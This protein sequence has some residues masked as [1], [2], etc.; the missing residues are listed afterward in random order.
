[1][2][3]FIR[4]AASHMQ[5]RAAI[6]AVAVVCALWTLALVKHDARAATEDGCNPTCVIL[7]QVDGLEPKDVTQQTTPYLWSLAHPQVAGNPLP[8]GALADRSGF[9]WQAPR[10]VMSTGTASATASLLTGAH[11]ERSGVPS[12]DFYDPT[13]GHQRLGAGGFGDQNLADDPGVSPDGAGP[14]GSSGVDTLVDAV[15][16]SGGDVAVF[17]GD[18]ALAR[19]AHADDAAA[20]WYP[21]GQDKTTS[22]SPDQKFTGDPRLC[23]IPRYPADTAPQGDQDHSPNPSACPADDATTMNKAASDLTNLSSTGSVAFTFIHLAELGVAKR[24][25]NISNDPNNSPPQPP[26]AL[27]DTDAAIATLAEQYARSKQDKWAK[28]VLMVVGSHGY[29]TATPAHRVPDPAAVSS[30]PNNATNATRDLSDYVQAFA[31][32]KNGANVVRAGELTLVP[33]GTLATIYY[34]VTQTDE[35]KID[36]ARR[37]DALAAIK[38]DLERPPTDSGSVNAACARVDPQ[39]DSSLRGC[40]REVDY[41]DAKTPGTSDTVD[42]RHPSW[43][44]DALKPDSPTRSNASGGLV[45]VLERGWATGRAA[46]TPRA[47]GLDPQPWSNPY[48]ASSGGPQERAV[49]ALINGPRRQ[50]STSPVAVRNLDTLAAG[51][52]KYYPVS[53]R[54]VDPDNPPPVTDADTKCPDTPPD[55]GGLACANDPAQVG[56]DAGTLGHEAQPVSVDF[57]ITIS[58]LMGVAFDT[59]PDQLQGRVLQEAFLNKLATP[60]VGDCEPPEV[61]IEP[62]PPPAPPPPPPLVV[63]P[64][65]F[66]FHGLLRNLS[67]R[68]VDGRNR[69]YARAKPGAVLSTIRLEGD[70]GK[71]ESAATLTFYRAV[72]RRRAARSSRVVQLKAIARFDPF[73]VKRGHVLI[74]LRVPASFSP[75]YIGLTVQEI[76]RGAPDARAASSVSCTPVKP[77]KPLRF[78]CIG[79]KRGVIVRI[80][81]AAKLHKRKR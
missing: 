74:K 38:A 42:A 39:P 21:P 20:H 69:T 29:Q 48:T 81:D 24:Q 71:P 49:A 7:I 25:A 33:Q 77:Q 46:G 52:V 43:H 78:D 9:I 17:L 75:T 14:V 53:K 4:D 47:S 26:Q 45:V 57:A 34:N 72:S 13:D 73:V 35:S 37:A 62:P 54:R 80:T 44:L 50:Q 30:D 66:N 59:H 58:A 68:V 40:I 5:G 79:P 18:A 19:V 76:A 55:V 27:A 2:P 15:K 16:Q 11:P 10:G 23:P 51:G 22:S 60:C 31:A 8:G 1:M 28:T 32:T 63:R 67:A 64:P 70:F 56:D 12:D 3:G 61:A 41:L 6:G 36:P 65:G